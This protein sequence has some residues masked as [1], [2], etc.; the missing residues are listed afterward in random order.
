MSASPVTLMVARRV[1]HGRYLDFNRWLNEGRELA[2][3][4]AGYLGS[5]VLAPPL[6]TMNIKSYSALATAKR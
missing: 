2:A 3:D 6:M 1:E 5:G 4:F